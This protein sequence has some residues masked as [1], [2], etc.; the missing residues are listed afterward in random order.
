[1]HPPHPHHGESA[2]PLRLSGPSEREGAVTL[3]LE[4]EFDLA[5]VPLFEDAVRAAVAGAA[6]LVVDLRGLEYIDSSGISALLRA[7]YRLHEAGGALQCVMAAEGTVRKV[8]EMTSVGTV[9]D[10]REAPPG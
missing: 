4:G 9:L 2:A 1:M 7:G 10:V 5:G 8:I 3:T 6:R